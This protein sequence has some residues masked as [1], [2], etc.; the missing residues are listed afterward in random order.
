MRRKD[1]SPC[2]SI[3]SS[4]HPYLASITPISQRKKDLSTELMLGL[5]MSPGSPNQQQDYDSRWVPSNPNLQQRA[6]FF[7]KVYMEG[8]LIGRKLDLFAQNGY[9]DLIITVK[10]LFAT[11]IKYP[12]QVSTKK[13]LVLTYQD[14]EGDW[15]LVGDAPWDMFLSSVMRLKIRRADRL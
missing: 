1:D 5:G 2:S 7:V 13:T 8:S 12:D 4:S 15:M 3:D 9:K 14:K 11:T 6:T 10:G